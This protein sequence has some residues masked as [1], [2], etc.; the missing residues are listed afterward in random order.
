MS[1]PIVV[2]LDS[3]DFSRFS[4]SH[5]DHWAYLGIKRELLELR[6]EG[7][8]RFV[9]SDIHVF[10][11]LPVSYK[12][13]APGLERIRTIAELCG[14]DHL[15]S[16]TALVEHELRQLA[17]DD[18][19]LW[20]EWYPYFDM[21]EPNRAEIEAD[22]IAKMAT[23]RNQ[24]RA[25]ARAF[26]GAPDVRLNQIWADGFLSE[27]P[28]L[29][30]GKK[31]L[32][33]YLARQLGWHAV[34]TLLRTGLRDI[35]GF[36]EW[37]AEN[38]KHGR[39]FV[40]SLRDQ[41]LYTQTTLID[42]HSKMRALFERASLSQGAAT[43]L[44]KATYDRQREQLLEDFAAKNSL[45]ILGKEVHAPLTQEQTPSLSVAMHFLMEVAFLS[46]LP[47]DPRNPKKHAGSDFADAMHV[48]FLPRVDIFRADQFSCSVLRKSAL[49][50]TTN[51]CPSLQDLPALIRGEAK[52][53]REVA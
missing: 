8:A 51:L 1:A 33:E 30:G 17:G 38:W 35:V 26:K 9:F 50:G 7:A 32:T 15:P 29:K 37:L 31:V 25:I 40:G 14:E 3:Q 11:N 48:L 41:N 12:N 36:S 5:P 23:N 16:S 47:K 22:L 44:I 46:A 49:N 34:E 6:Q 19:L 4:P 42:L 27:Y 24:R 18:A 21:K 10:E 52:K 13:R 2:Y 20:P 39:A 45:K 53:R 28:F 43:Q